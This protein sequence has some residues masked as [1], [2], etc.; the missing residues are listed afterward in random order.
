VILR[1]L[2]T[3]QPLPTV[4]LTIPISPDAKVYFFALLLALASGLVFGAVPARQTFRTNPYELVKSS[5]GYRTGRRMTVREVLLVVQIAIC[6]VLVTSSFVAVRGLV[7]SLHA[8]LGFEPR[9][10]MLVE[11]ALS[12]AGYSGDAV[13]AMQKRMID[14]LQAIPGVQSVGLVDRLPLYYGANYT[15]IFSDKTSDL[16]PSNVAAR[17]TMYLISPEYFQ[18]AG[19]SLLS[20]RAFTWHDDTSAPRVAVINRQFARKIFGS[21][22]AAV[23]GYFKLENIT[24]VQVVGVVEDG[25]Y[26]TLAEEPRPAMFLPILQSP[27]TQTALV[28]RSERDQQEIA[29]AIKRT[30]TGLDSGLPITLRSWNQELES[31]L[32]AS[33]MATLSLGVL[34]TLGAML[35]VTGIFGMAAYSV[36]KRLREFGIRVALGAK[37]AELLHTALGRALKLLAFG[38]AA[39]LFLGIL[40]T[41]VLAYIVYQAAPNDPMVLGGAVLA[42]SLLGL[43]ATWIPARRALNVDPNLLLRE[44]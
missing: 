37:R 14:A 36:S 16:R 22:S 38:S 2:S 42:M 44:E 23:G 32:F 28:I 6:A 3:W 31:A 24:R 43:L 12:M 17:P 41:K 20:G 19:T 30:V 8:N 29:A 27:S 34:G 10:A 21:V 18:A 40:A 11:T 26:D 39:G 13:P 1:G 5:S 35:A 25:K 4:P 7:R 33:R 9:N 15:N